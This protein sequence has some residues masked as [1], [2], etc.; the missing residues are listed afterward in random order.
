MAYEVA[1]LDNNAEMLAASAGVIVYA[2]EHGLLRDKGKPVHFEVM[3]GQKRAEYCG[4]LEEVGRT[5]IFAGTTRSESE[6]VN[7]VIYVLSE[8][9]AVV[10]FEVKITFSSAMKGHLIIGCVDGKFRHSFEGDNLELLHEFIRN[11][12][13]TGKLPRAIEKFGWKATERYFRSKLG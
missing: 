7:Q 1:A 3:N 11:M 13:F 4:V 9:G 10:S 2:R 12:I 5:K 8:K 6:S